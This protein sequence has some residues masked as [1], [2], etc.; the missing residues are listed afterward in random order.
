MAVKDKMEAKR[1]SLFQKPGGL[2]SDEAFS[3]LMQSA[4]A[5]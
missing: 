2:D 4:I 3:G 1:L 5:S